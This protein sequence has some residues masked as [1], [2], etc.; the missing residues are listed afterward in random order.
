MILKMVIVEGK[1]SSFEGF[2]GLNNPWEITEMR[3]KIIMIADCD[4]KKAA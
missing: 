4:S 1:K 3:I 2:M